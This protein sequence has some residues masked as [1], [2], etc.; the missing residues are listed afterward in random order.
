MAK[1]GMSGTRIYRIWRDMKARCDCP[2]STNYVNY[3]AR[4]I[5][6]CDA[7]KDFMTFHDWAMA[8]G[9]SSVLTLERKDNSLG[10]NPSNCVFATKV[11]Q[12]CNRRSFKNS[13]SEYLGVYLTAQKTWAAK[14]KVS[15]KNVHLGCFKTELEAAQ[16]RDDYIKANSLPHKL[17]IG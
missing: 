12:Q 2:S 11:E 9:Y 1:H 10:Y 3:G 8:N 15:G 16:F 5:T 7:W 14:V 13:T 4:G 17:N 6:Y